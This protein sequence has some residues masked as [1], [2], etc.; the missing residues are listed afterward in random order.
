MK[1]RNLAWVKALL[2]ASLLLAAVSSAFAGAGDSAGGRGRNK[3]FD[4]RPQAPRS[5]R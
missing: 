1:N 4:A 3:G 2:I 5:F